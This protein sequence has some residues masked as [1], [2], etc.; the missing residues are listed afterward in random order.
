M[1][2]HK[3]MKSTFNFL[4]VNMAIGDLLVSL[5][6]MPSEVRKKCVTFRHNICSFNPARYET[7]ITKAKKNVPLLQTRALHATI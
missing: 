5:F 1:A 2:S 4:I 7:M 6:I 3:T